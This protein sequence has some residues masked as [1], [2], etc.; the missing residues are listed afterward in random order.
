MSI[1]NFKTVEQGQIFYKYYRHNLYKVL[2]VIDVKHGQVYYKF[3]SCSRN[4][5]GNFKRQSVSV[6]QHSMH[7]ILEWINDPYDRAQLYEFKVNL[8]Q[9]ER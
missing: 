8:K 4:N 6:P 3:G 2:A 9:L 7:T 5:I 1:A